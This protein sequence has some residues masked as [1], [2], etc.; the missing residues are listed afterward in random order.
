M[1]AYAATVT[2]KPTGRPFKVGNSLEM[3]KG[4]VDITNYNTTLAEITAITDLFRD[5]PIVVPGAITDNGY[6]ITWI[7]ASKAFKA[8]YPTNSSDQTP[9]AD[10]VAA[11]AA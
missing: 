10:I 2:L 7:A 5:V 3:I 6:L 8:W 1:A 11:A 9:T 4:T